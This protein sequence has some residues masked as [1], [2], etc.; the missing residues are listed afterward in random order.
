MGIERRMS[1]DIFAATEIVELKQPCFTS[2]GVLYP[3][4]YPVGQLPDV[5]FEM[6]LVD[7]VYPERGKAGKEEQQSPPDEPGGG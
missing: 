4:L 7:R 1:R 3:G 6:G 2:T 5:A